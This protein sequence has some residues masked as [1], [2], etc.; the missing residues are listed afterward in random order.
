MAGIK[1]VP[2]AELAGYAGQKFGPTDWVTLSQ[3]RINQ[4]ADVT[5]DHQFIHIDEDAAAA[6]PFGGTIAHGFLC[7]SMLAHF[8]GQAGVLPEGVLMGIN[9]GMNKVRFLQPV[10]AGKRIRAWIKPLSFKA[11]PGSQLL[12]T[13]EVTV[14]IEGEQKPALIAEMLALLILAP[15]E[16]P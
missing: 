13:T 3:D 5:L 14:E 1:T 9:Y 8:Q 2:R 6:T 10:R 15:E 7:L 11:R 12:I 16:N 4:F